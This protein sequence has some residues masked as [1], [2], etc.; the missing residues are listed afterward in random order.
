MTKSTAMMMQIATADGESRQQM[1]VFANKAVYRRSLTSDTR[2]RWRY[3]SV[4][5]LPTWVAGYVNLTKSAPVPM[6]LSHGPV[7]IEVTE[8]ESTEAEGGS[9]A[10]NVGLRYQRV[11]DAM[12]SDGTPMILT[13]DVET[14]VKEWQ[15]ANTR[16]DDAWLDARIHPAGTARAATPPAAPAPM[17]APVTPVVATGAAAVA[18]THGWMYPEVKG[19]YVTRPNGERYK[20]RKIERTA[21]VTVLQESRAYG[22]HVFLF[23]EPGTGKTALVEAAFGSDLVT[24]LGTED[25]EVSDFIG[26]Y[27]P[28]GGGTYGWSDGAM[29]EAMERDVPL[30]IDEIGVIAPKVLT[31][32]FSVMD[33]RGELRVTANPDRGVIKC[34]PGFM[35]IA[36]TNPHAPGVRLSEA[37][38]SRFAVHVEVGSDYA[39]ARELGVPDPLVTA[40]ENLD[41]RRTTGEIRWAPQMR[42]LLRAKSQWEKRS[43]TFAYRNLISSAPEDDREVVAEVLARTAGKKITGLSL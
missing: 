6:E 29:A 41:K 9:L 42:E 2:T 7:L 24:M 39:M 26:Q 12:D 18:A 22:E 30:F 25:T 17:V 23:G 3:A 32:V 38:L 8:D 15:D 28:R 37:L 11:L 35:V 1:V 5:E 40:A 19:G 4:G 20:V 43:E 10:R 14:Y 21:D 33:G 31:T 16:S 27:G 13:G 34:G 36:A